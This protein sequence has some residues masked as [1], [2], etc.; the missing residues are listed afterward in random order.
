MMNIVIIWNSH[1]KY[2]VFVTFEG[3]PN[4]LNIVT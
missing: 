1:R 2:F 3:C 4:D